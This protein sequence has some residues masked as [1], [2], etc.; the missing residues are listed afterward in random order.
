MSAFPREPNRES[1]IDPYEYVLAGKKVL[2]CSLPVPVRDRQGAFGEDGGEGAGCEGG[3]GQ[4][5]AGLPAS[6]VRKL[7][8]RS[9]NAAGEI[10]ELSASRVHVAEKAG[11]LL[12]RIVPDI[13]KTTELVQEISATL[14]E[15]NAAS[16]TRSSRTATLT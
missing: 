16:A 4:R 10:G 8:E 14:G 12:A 7:A 11:G 2:L 13:Q 6:E 5:G 3:L 15:Q 1:V 9:R